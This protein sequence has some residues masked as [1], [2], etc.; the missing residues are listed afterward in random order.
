MDKKQIVLKSCASQR[1]SPGLLQSVRSLETNLMDPGVSLCI[2]I[3]K[4][5]QE[6]LI[7]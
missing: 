4:N 6:I 1:N 2:I 7:K 3:F 5:E